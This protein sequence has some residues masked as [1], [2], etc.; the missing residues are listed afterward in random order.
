MDLFDVIGKIP[1]LVSLGINVL[2]PLPVYQVDQ[3]FAAGQRSICNCVA[4]Y[5]HGRA[6]RN[7]FIARATPAA[8][9]RK[10]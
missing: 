4:E 9:E 5:G 2:Q 8:L 7:E 3:R 6:A 1:Y 10:M